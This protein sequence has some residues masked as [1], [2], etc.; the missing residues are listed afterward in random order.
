MVPEATCFGSFG[1]VE[2]KYLYLL[3][4]YARGLTVESIGFRVPCR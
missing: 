3:F 1:S 4:K 2:G